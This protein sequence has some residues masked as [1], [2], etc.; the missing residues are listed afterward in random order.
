MKR[1]DNNVFVYNADARGSVLS[2]IRMKYTCGNPIHYQIMKF[3]NVYVR[4]ASIK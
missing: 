1:A 4:N 2:L 3:T